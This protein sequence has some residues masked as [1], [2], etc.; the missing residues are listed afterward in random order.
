MSH[1]F[2]YKLS[3]RIQ[4]IRVHILLPLWFVQLLCTNVNTLPIQLILKY[5]YT[6]T[7]PYAGFRHPDRMAPDQTVRGGEN[8]CFI[9]SGY[10]LAQVPEFSS[11]F[12]NPGIFLRFTWSSVRRVLFLCWYFTFLGAG[13]HF[14]NFPEITLWKMKECTRW[15]RTQDLRNTIPHLYLYTT[16]TLLKKFKI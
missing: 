3:E 11:I 5:L 6:V 8:D 7:R 16:T 4:R 15:D 1:F 12:Q 10:F 9:W 13:R 14:R 2:I